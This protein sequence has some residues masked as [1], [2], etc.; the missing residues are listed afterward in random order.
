MIELEGI[1]KSYWMGAV[2]MPVLHGI[3]LSIADG[4]MVAI[5]GPSGSGK[6][7]MMN[8]L[9]CLDVPTSG[10][11]ELDGIDVSKLSKR[12]LSRT[13]GSKIGFVFQ[14]FN[15]I[16]R[17]DAMRNVELPLVYSGIRGRHRRARAALEQVGLG[18]RLHHMPNE[19]SGGQKQR[20]AIAR[21]LINEPSI[22]LADEPTGA[23]DT[24]SS[25]EIM[26]LLVDL[27]NTG[28]TI[29]VIT[30]EE[31][32]AEFASRIVRLRDGRIGSDE[33]VLERATTLPDADHLDLDDDLDADLDADDE[34]D[35][36]LDAN[37][38]DAE[39]D[40]ELSA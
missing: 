18:E 6:S 24:K 40:S 1:T 8:I 34:L 4:E 10:R 31:E 36:E 28:A 26:K 20:V 16:P 35:S 33:P 25:V 38:L 23:L 7:T 3:D 11:Y 12:E 32:I 21:A 9:G 17:T 19:L 39:V 30:H 2:E 22:L 5:M 14:S 29:V 27:N 15:L 37:L 13:R